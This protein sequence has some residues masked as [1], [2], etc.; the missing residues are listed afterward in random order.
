MKPANNGIGAQAPDRNSALSTSGVARR[1]LMKIGAAAVAGLPMLAG[2]PLLAEPV[3]QQPAAAGATPGP[4]PSGNAAAAA[5]ESSG[6]D[7]P[8]R[9]LVDYAASFSDANLSDHAVEA[10][11]Y[12][13]LDTMAALVAGFEAEPVRIG[14]RMARQS[15]SELK[16]TVMG[17]GITT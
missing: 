3:A 11:S 10:A 2:S 8:T 5:S 16:S 7:E 6:W 9:Q 1:E 12:T 15:S 14:A 17:Y 4:P 13:L